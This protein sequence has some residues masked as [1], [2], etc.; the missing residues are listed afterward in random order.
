M[1]CYLERL[2]FSIQ[3]LDAESASLVPWAL[4][5]ITDNF[6]ISFGGISFWVAKLSK[7]FLLGHADRNLCRIALVNVTRSGATAREKTNERS[8]NC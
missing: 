7:N 1:I 4:K 8:Q 5:C 2:D 3:D 6:R